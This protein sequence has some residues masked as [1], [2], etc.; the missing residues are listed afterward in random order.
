MDDNNTNV[1]LHSSESLKSE[2]QVLAWW[3]PSGGCEGGICFR[4]LSLPYGH[5]LSVSLHTVFSL[6]LSLCP[7]LP[8]LKGHQP[9]GIRDHSKDLT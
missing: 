6:C 5:L 1:S 8:L 7:D 4:C 3:V 9:F 2:I